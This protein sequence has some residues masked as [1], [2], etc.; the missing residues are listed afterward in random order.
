MRLLAFLLAALAASACSGD[1]DG[2]ECAQDE[3]CVSGNI[4]GVCQPNNY[5]SFPDPACDSGQRYAE[6]A[7]SGFAEQCVPPGVAE[8]SGSGG[9]Q[10][11]TADDEPTTSDSDATTTSDPDATTTSDVDASCVE[12][13]LGSALGEVDARNFSQE[14]DD[15]SPSCESDDG[16][17]VVYAFVAPV[18]GDYRFRA[19]GSFTPVVVSLRESCTGSELACETNVFDPFSSSVV[20]SLDQGERLIVVVDTDESNE[21]E[22]VLEIRLLE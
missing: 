4:A 2:F 21:G 19:S 20:R 8:S 9:P 12:V 7:P 5:C 3:E 17:D 13:D 1:G 10:P 16:N 14:D 11:T 18:P 6:L 22:F 15:F